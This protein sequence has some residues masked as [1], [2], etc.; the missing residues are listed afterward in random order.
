MKRTVE[1]RQLIE[2]EIDESKFDEQFMQE[3]RESFYN[4]TTL[5]DHIAHI[6]QL[7]ARGMLG[8]FIEGYGPAKDMGIKAEVKSWDM[9]VLR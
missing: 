9:E 5:D 1:V 7:E 6:G 8:T 2:V 4:F 3:F